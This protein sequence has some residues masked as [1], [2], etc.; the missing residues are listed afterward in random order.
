MK[1][2]NRRCGA[3]SNSATC[4]TAAARISNVRVEAKTWASGGKA[5]GWYDITR[6]AAQRVENSAASRGELANF[7]ERAFF[8]AEESHTVID[9]A[10]YSITV[11]DDNLTL[12][13]K[14]KVQARGVRLADVQS[15]CEDEVRSVMRR[16]HD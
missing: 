10:G 9:S 3:T 15:A 7:G 2:A 4:K 11:V 8:E 6:R 16:L 14:V 12:E 5:D 13:V 1:A